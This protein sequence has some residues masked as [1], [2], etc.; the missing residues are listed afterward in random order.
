MTKVETISQADA[1]S[2]ETIGY[3]HRRELQNADDVYIIGSEIVYWST[4]TLD[5]GYTIT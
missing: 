5:Q 2:D 4:N 3:M 1:Y